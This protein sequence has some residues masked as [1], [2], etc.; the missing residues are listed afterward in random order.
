MRRRRSSAETTAGLSSLPPGQAGDAVS[1]TRK[2]LA[3]WDRIKFL[4]LLGLVWWLLVWALKSNDWQVPFT[5]AM[6]IET[7]SGAWVFVLLGLEAMRQV[8]FLISEHW[9]RYHRFWTVTFFG[10]FD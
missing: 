3:P 6:R 7:R 1:A 8:H 2:R 4:L 9:A 10:G 5:D